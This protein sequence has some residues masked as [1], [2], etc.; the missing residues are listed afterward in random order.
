[1]NLKFIFLLITP[2]IIVTSYILLSAFQTCQI[3]LDETFATTDKYEEL[4]RA[5]IEDDGTFFK[6]HDAVSDANLPYEYNIYEQPMRK[7]EY[8]YIVISTYKKVLGR[9]P[10]L[11]ELDEHVADFTKGKLTED[12]LRTYLL[13]SNEYAMSARLQSDHVNS[14]IE[15]AYAKE[16][17]LLMISTMYFDELNV[18]APKIMLLP[19]RDVFMYLK[20]NTNMFRAFLLDENYSKFENEVMT[21]KKLRKNNMYDIFHKHIDLE[22][23]RLKANDIER[24]D[25]LT[26]ADTDFVPIAL[27]SSQT[28]TV[29]GPESELGSGSGIKFE[30]TERILNEMKSKIHLE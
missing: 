1:M 10:G 9:S 3:T 27:P 11:D 24:Y 23:L 4:A 16:D 22:R 29:V 20:H 5:V 2:I 18:E 30:D 12:L 25:L 14:D 28:G 26:K 21:T 13:N 19:L 7:N 8:E 17:L 15:Y 6:Q